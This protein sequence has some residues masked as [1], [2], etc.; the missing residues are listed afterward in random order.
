M[1]FVL[2]LLDLLN[3]LAQFLFFKHLLVF[4]RNY[5]YEFWQVFIPVDKNLFGQVHCVYNSNGC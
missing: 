3:Q 4:Q 5:F 2:R 1:R